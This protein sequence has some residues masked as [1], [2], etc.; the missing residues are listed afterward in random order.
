MENENNN[1][2]QDSTYHFG[3]NES[4]FGR[5]DISGCP[6]VENQDRKIEIGDTEQNVLQGDVET[7]K[8]ITEE[9]GMEQ[10]Q[11]QS[12]ATYYTSNPYQQGSV[13]GQGIYTGNDFK[14]AE[15]I[16]KRE[17]KPHNKPNTA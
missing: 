13:Y 12:G 10:S 17:K 8:H 3:R 16:K 7:G 15:S 2:N 11:Q 1:M 9:S 4:P 6:I 5:E 14:E